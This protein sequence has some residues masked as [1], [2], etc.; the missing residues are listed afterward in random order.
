MVVSSSTNSWQRQPW[1]SVPGVRCGIRLV[2]QLAQGLHRFVFVR[3]LLVP[4][5]RQSSKPIVAL[6]LSLAL[7]CGNGSSFGGAEDAGKL[8]QDT[9]LFFQ[10][11]RG[12]PNVALIVVDDDASDGGRALRAAVARDFREHYDASRVNAVS[13]C[14]A[15]RDPALPSLVRRHA[16]VIAGSATGDDGV[17]SFVEDPELS[18]VAQERLDDDALSWSDAVAQAIEASET[19]EPGRYQPLALAD[20]WLRLL[21]REVAPETE[22]ELA[23]VAALPEA[24]DVEAFLASVRDDDSPLPASE[25]RLEPAVNCAGAVCAA[26]VRRFTPDPTLECCSLSAGR[27]PRLSEQAGSN[28][29]AARA[30]FEPCARAYFF[31]VGFVEDCGPRCQREPL[32]A[33]SGA[34]ECRVLVAAAKD[35]QCTATAGFSDTSL[36]SEQMTAWF[37]STAGFRLCEIQ[38]LQG[39][40]LDAC[41]NDL[42]CAGCTPGF[43]VTRVPELVGDCSHIGHFPLALRFPGLP[44]R[45]KGMLLE[46]RCNVQP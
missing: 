28:Q 15:P 6:G 29:T 24:V 14:A 3:L 13:S 22:R 35:E 45:S 33:A 39:D 30:C 16:I 20:R 46:A 41:V 27:L 23:V 26:E 32:I 18:W 42:D 17:H 40:A 12:I 19:G 36:E 34:A 8:R 37:G 21:A 25:Y 7:G 31:D 44:E 2:R 1:L 43:C 11:P 9:Q 10:G 5:E 4:L 38:Q